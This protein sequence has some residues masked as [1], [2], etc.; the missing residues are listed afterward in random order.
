MGKPHIV[1]FYADQK[2][3]RDGLAF[4][5]AR[6]GKLGS[7]HIPGGG[8]IFAD[9]DTIHGALVHQAGDINPFNGRAAP[10]LT[11]A[12]EDEFDAIVGTVAEDVIHFKLTEKA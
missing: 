8:V 2:G 3:A 7:I 10:I 12:P 5:A 4:A 1:Y 11:G 9:G 6:A